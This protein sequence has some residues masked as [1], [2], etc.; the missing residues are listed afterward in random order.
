M[1]DEREKL[2]AKNL[3]NYSCKVMPGQK[4]LIEYSDISKGF[5]H[6]LI[7]E[8]FLAGGL[9]FYRDVGKDTQ[10]L[11]V[12]QGSAELFKQMAKY[13]SLQMEDMDAVILALGA[14]NAFEFAG[15]DALQMASFNTNYYKPVHLQ[16]RITKKWVTLRY[17]TPAFAQ[18][19]GVSTQD[20]ED[21][22]FKVCN[23]DYGKMKLAIEP[24][25]NLM[26]KTDKVKI[27]A[28]N[29]N[30][31]FSIKGIP[32]VPC[33][34]EH[35]VPDGEIYTAPVKD[36][37]FGEIEFNI[38]ALI[39]G[40]LHNNIWLK[41]E[42]GKIVEAKS[43]NTK[44]LQELI[45]T[46][47]G[48]QYLGEFAFGVNPHITAPINDILF[49]EKMCYS[50]HFAIGNSYDNAFNGNLSS[51]HADLIQLHTEE[52]GGGKVYFD[53]VLIRKNGQ[54]MLSELVALNPENL[55]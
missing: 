19:A 37:V 48:S 16:C 28:K 5:L 43:S 32:S 49:D 54:F 25:K 18:F 12:R 8:V 2:L 38:P 21:F 6:A 9:P 13:H 31:E 35:N 23:L 36:S 22:Y 10:K 27:V 4:V 52:F 26:E 50:L 41:F 45:A 14:N 7:N 20:F 29:T 46:D 15:I 33:C 3:V 11:I 39:G 17:P 34:G 47:E 53:D 51:I 44:A 1:V 55:V 30:L 42:K 24:L 40:V